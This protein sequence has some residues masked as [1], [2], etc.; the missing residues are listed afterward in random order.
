MSEIIGIVQLRPNLGR[1][2]HL[3][4]RDRT[5]I[6][7]FNDIG[8]I[9]EIHWNR[10]STYVTSDGFRYQLPKVT[11]RYRNSFTI[12]SLGEFDVLLNEDY[13]SLSEF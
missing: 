6:D 12:T 4:L 13:K 2:N 10:I 7:S 5:I 8:E 1:R 9:T 11:I 3:Q